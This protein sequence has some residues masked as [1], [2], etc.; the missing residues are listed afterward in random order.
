MADAT[1]LYG[2][3]PMDKNVAYEALVP[4]EKG[5]ERAVAAGAVAA[6]DVAALDHARRHDAVELGPFVVQRLA[7]LADALFAR[8]Q[9]P[10]ILA[11]F[12]GDVVA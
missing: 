11:R 1:E 7:H 6:R 12:P 8:A 9:R 10:E 4:N 3:L 5:Y 2:R